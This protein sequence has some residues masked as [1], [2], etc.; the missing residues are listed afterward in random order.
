LPAL[1][2]PD[3]DWA[4]QVNKDEPY[5][6]GK[7]NER[8]NFLNQLIAKETDTIN[9]ELTPQYNSSLHTVSVYDFKAKT[10][11]TAQLAVSQA[12]ILIQ[13]TIIS[14]RSVKLALSQLTR[15][16]AFNSDQALAQ[17]IRATIANAKMDDSTKSK[18]EQLANA[19]EL[20]ELNQADWPNVEKKILNDAISGQAT[21]ADGL[22]EQLRS[23]ND[24]LNSDLKQLADNELQDQNNTNALA[25]AISDVQKKISDYQAE[26]AQLQK[27]N[28]NSANVMKAWSVSAK[29]PHY[30]P[31]RPMRP[32][33]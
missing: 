23:L 1:A 21:L 33:Y 4:I 2:S 7:R 17:Q 31:P 32:V 8:I 30:G 12:I 15:T 9:K 18:I 11:K 22:V 13:N 24:E 19:V 6:I 10:A 25:A 28:A 26:I 5:R 3:C 14:T 20:V 27:D 16:A 29:C